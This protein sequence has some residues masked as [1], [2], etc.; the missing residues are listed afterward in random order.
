M[1]ARREL[2]AETEALRMFLSRLRQVLATAQGQAMAESLHV[3]A[4]L[5]EARVRAEEVVQ[6]NEA[7][8]GRPE[9]SV[10]EAAALLEGTR[11]VQ[12][13][14]AS[15]ARVDAMIDLQE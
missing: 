6:V 8:L 4:P 10:E 9:A 5:N 15:S 13:V 12:A 11:Q 1:E 3:A 14:L 7:F 2:C